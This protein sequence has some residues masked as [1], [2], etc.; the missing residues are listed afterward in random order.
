M[1]YTLVGLVDQVCG[2]LG[3]AQPS[4]VIGSG[5]NQTAQFL[6]LAQ[7]LLQDLMR[8]YQWQRSVRSYVLTTTAALS[9]TGTTVSGSA[10]IT[11][12]SN[13]TS[14]AA[15]QVV[16]GTGIAPYAQILTVDSA[17]QVTLDT[18][19]TASGTG[20]TL[21]FAYQ[22]YAL[23]TGFDRMVAD[24]QWDRT[25]HWRNLGSTS[26]QQWQTLQGGVISVGPRVRYRIYDDKLRIFPALTTV[27]SFSF[28]YVDYRTA[29]VSGGSTAIKSLF[30]LDSDTCIFPDT[31]MLSGLRYYFLKAKKLDYG[32]EMA[33][34]NDALS[35]AKAVDVPISAMSLA[36]V[37]QDW[38]IGQNSIPD[39][40]WSTTSS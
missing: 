17:T 22:D 12:M 26:S 30:T 36:P 25:D 9:K 4:V 14:L 7:R 34:F 33:E 18:P 38:L 8:D 35:K 21:T 16:S 5:A 6:A 24:T 13:T 2:E 10:V 37:Q 19:A 20:T 27:Y 1:A 39:G 32:P 15:A 3:L 29:I 40:S 31:V 23:P 11:S 28:E